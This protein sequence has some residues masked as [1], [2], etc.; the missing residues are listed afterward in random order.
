MTEAPSG[1]ERIRP[2]QLHQTVGLADG[3]V[4]GERACACLRT[5]S[6]AAGAR[7][8]PAISELPVSRTTLPIWT[9]GPTA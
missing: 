4:P 5:G 6:L 3:R 7:L 2:K 9:C 8:A 1:Y